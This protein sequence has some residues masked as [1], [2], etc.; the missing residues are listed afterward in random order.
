MLLPKTTFP[1]ADALNRRLQS[2]EVDIARV[3]STA[4]LSNLHHAGL[5]CVTLEYYDSIGSRY[6]RGLRH[7]YTECK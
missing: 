4:T 3:V 6:K 1:L 7:T 5:L 2:L